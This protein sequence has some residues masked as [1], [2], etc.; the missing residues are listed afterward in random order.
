VYLQTGR[1]TVSWD[2]SKEMQGEGGDCMPLLD[3]HGDPFGV[4]HPGLGPPVWDG[5][6]AVEADSGRGGP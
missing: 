5:C 3:L 6:G 2:V 1:P 4:L